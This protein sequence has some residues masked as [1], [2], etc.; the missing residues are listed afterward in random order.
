MLYCECQFPASPDLI[1]KVRSLEHPLP[2]P[3]VASNLMSRK[4]KHRQ[5]TVFTRSIGIYSTYTGE[6]LNT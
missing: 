6:A 1:P 2:I 4:T 3:L 5:S